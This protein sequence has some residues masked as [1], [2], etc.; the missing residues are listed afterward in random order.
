ME[1]L[2]FHVLSHSPISSRSTFSSLTSLPVVRVARADVL[3]RL[4]VHHQTSRNVPDAVK[5]SGLGCP[6]VH[7]LQS[8]VQPVVKFRPDTENTFFF[9]FSMKFTGT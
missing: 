2:S 9:S 3:G 8:S 1:A 7:S 5:F 4:D 6:N